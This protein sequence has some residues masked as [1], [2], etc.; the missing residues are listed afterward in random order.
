[1]TRETGLAAV[2]PEI[3]R[4]DFDAKKVVG[5]PMPW[6]N[7]RQIAL[8]ANTRSLDRSGIRP[9]AAEELAAALRLG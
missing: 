5:E 6:K 1:M 8:I 9:G 3:A 7:H 2:L 4:V